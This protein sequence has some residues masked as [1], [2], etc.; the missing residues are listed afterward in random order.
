MNPSG[1]ITVALIDPLWIGHHPMYFNQFSASFLRNGA[2][3]IG[4]C[5]EP[6]AARENFHRATREG[7]DGERIWFSHLPAGKRSFFNG[8]FE[9][10]PARTFA[11]W[12]RAA[13]WLTQAEAESGWRADLVYF[14]YLDSAGCHPSAAMERALSSQPPSW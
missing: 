8:R 5:P 10:D 6:D 4:L 9:G 2:R 7:T 12:K 1:G 11:R 13:D 14:P 3:V